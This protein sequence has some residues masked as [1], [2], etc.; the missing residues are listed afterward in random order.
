[1]RNKTFYTLL[2]IFFGLFIIFLLMSFD[3]LIIPL[4][5]FTFGD[6]EVKTEGPMEIV[7]MIIAVI[8][9]CLMILLVV[10]K[11]YN[12]IKKARE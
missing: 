6:M 9:A 4:S 2:V 11:I 5:T 12:E 8:F 3:I 10:V 1:M 7:F